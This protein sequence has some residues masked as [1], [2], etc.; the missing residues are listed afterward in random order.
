MTSGRSKRIL[1][2]SPV[3]SYTSPTPWD[4]VRTKA[5]LKPLVPLLV[6]RF[7]VV[8][9]AAWRTQRWHRSMGCALKC[10]TGPSDAEVLSHCAI[11]ERKPKR[12]ISM[13]GAL[14]VAPPGC[15]RTKALRR[16]AARKRDS[17][18]GR[19]VHAAGEYSLISPPSMRRRL[20]REGRGQSRCRCRKL[21]LAR[22][23]ESVR[24]GH[25]A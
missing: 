2:L 3:S 4:Q 19:E 16:C 7:S 10:R 24:P 21:D 14:A 11:R 18:G 25:R 22:T 5:K 20:M 17:V 13:A 8:D 23:R 15:D 12:P 9:S 6:R 1:L